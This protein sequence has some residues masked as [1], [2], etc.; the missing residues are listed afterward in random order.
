VNT[1]ELR[2]FGFESDLHWMQ[3]HWGLEGYSKAKDDIT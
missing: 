1:E 3:F 2:I